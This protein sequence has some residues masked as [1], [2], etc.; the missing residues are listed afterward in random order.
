MATI[1]MR[2][3]FGDIVLTLEKTSES[4][5]LLRLNQTIG[6]EEL[7]GICNLSFSRVCILP[8]DLDELLST[9][10]MY[11]SLR[12]GLG[13]AWALRFHGR[14]MVYDLD[15]EDVKD[16]EF[17]EWPTEE[18]IF[19]ATIFVVPSKPMKY[20]SCKFETGLLDW[21]YSGTLR[22]ETISRR[23][24]ART[25]YNEESGSSVNV[26]ASHV[27]L[28]SYLRERNPLNARNY[29]TQ[30]QGEP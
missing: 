11:N 4:S 2:G 25:P 9:V 22:F 18:K 24:N 15:S 19:E 20:S 14:Y 7:T 5:L 26:A 3:T 29:D 1:K 13:R 30:A 12:S 16:L 6:E 8:E 21:Q 28:V 17:D 10:T 23:I 27:D